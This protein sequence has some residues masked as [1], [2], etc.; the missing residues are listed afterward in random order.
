MNISCI[1]HVPF[2][3][4]MKRALC[5]WLE[6]E[7]HSLFSVSGD[8]SREKAM[9]LHKHCTVSRGEVK[10]GFH[11]SEWWFENSGKQMSLHKLKRNVESAF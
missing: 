9:W 5:V 8:V 2:L 3:E 6:D 4:K 11:V 1:I 7:A 10:N